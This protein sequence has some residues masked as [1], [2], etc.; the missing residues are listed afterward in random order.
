MVDRIRPI[1]LATL[2]NLSRTE[3]GGKD[4]TFNIHEISSRAAQLFSLDYNDMRNSLSK[5]LTGAVTSGQDPH[6]AGDPYH[7]FYMLTKAGQDFQAMIVAATAAAAS[8][9][10][11]T[12]TRPSPYH[13]H[14]SSNASAN[15]DDDADDDSD[16]DG[17]KCTQNK[18]VARK[19]SSSSSCSQRSDNHPS[20]YNNEQSSRPMSNP[21]TG[22]N[23]TDCVHHSYLNHNEL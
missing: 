6:F 4:R 3:D 23:Y 15:D 10:P 22:T 20:A 12:S 7:E 9:V 17:D 19:P 8:S 2:A 11:T 16:R 13:P 21:S 14:V 5:Y 1:A 18:S